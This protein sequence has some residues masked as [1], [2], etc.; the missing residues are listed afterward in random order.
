[1]YSQMASVFGDVVE[2]D[3]WA[4]HLEAIV[5]YCCSIWRLGK[6]YE[7]AV[8]EECGVAGERKW[9]RLEDETGWKGW[10]L[11]TG[12]GGGVDSESDS[13]LLFLW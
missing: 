11:T 12:E 2:R 7:G 9:M 4:N 13:S 8:K 6:V 10:G 5:V 3:F 1:M